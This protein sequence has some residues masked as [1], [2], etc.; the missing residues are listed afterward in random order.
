M[1]LQII[2]KLHELDGNA[3]IHTLT[4]MLFDIDDSIT[5]KRFAENNDLLMVHNSYDNNNTSTIYNECRSFV[6]KLED[7]NVRMVAYSHENM[8]EV[9]QNDFSLGD[10]DEVEQGYE[11]TSVSVFFEQQWYFTTTRCTNIDSSYFYNTKI[12]F[13]QL[14]DE[15]LKNIDMD[16]ETFTDKLDK[17]HCY[18]FVIVHH[19]NKYV[20]DYTEEFGNE[21]AKLVQVIEC[22]MN[23]L[24]QVH[25]TNIPGV[26][27]PQTFQCLE[28]CN[29]PIVICKRFDSDR[30]TYQYFKL[31]TSEH[32]QKCARKPKFTNNWYSYVQI[33][34]NNNPDFT[35][36]NFR[37]EN[38]ITDNYNVNDQDVNIVGM[39]FLLYKRTASILLD[40]VNHFTEFD[41]EHQ[42]FTKINSDDYEDLD[43]PEF[44][45]LRHQI[46]TLQNLVR[47]GKIRT[48][49]NI[50]S[51]LRRYVNVHQF[52]KIIR[53]LDTLKVKSYCNF[54]NRYY[55]DYVSFLISQINSNDTE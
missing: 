54:D 21:Y 53:A 18:N 25:D 13:G 2:E 29:S 44:A 49:S 50:V 41:Y 40:L 47:K 35:I 10:Y 30:D 4:D 51:H 3:N 12:T 48:S 7:S 11:G 37:D 16:R 24:T 8:S 28:D 9:L 20:I 14:F 26:I 32:I 19:E 34:L 1:P 52:M 17:T 5:V 42:T 39:I 31:Q 23:H 45:V 38:N 33:Y 15:C 43:E 22:E 6:I 27:V 55:E 36:D 46:A